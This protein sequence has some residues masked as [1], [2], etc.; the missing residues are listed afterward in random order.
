M[1][2]IVE[3]TPSPNVIVRTRNFVVKHRAKIAVATT[4]VVA[5]YIYN[6]SQTDEDEYADTD[7]PTLES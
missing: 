7:E 6:A 3:E 4:L 2:P 1:E 5:G